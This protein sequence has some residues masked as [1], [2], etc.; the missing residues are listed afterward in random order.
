M[1]EGG[2]GLLMPGCVRGGYYCL[3]GCVLGE[4][5]GYSCLCVVYCICMGTHWNQLYI[6]IRPNWIK[7][8]GEEYHRE[9]FVM[10]GFQEDDLHHLERLRILLLEQLHALLAVQLYRT[11]GI[12]SHIAAYQVVATNNKTVI[13]LSSLKNKQLYS[14]L[15]MATHTLL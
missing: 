4:G 14:I 6:F 13:L 9:E 12:N 11:N 10:T 1:Y 5:G 15:V 2:G 7:I 8:Y 3:H